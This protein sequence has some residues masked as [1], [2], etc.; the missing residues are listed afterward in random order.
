[1]IAHSQGAVVARRALQRLREAG[2]TA[3]LDRVQNLV[4]LG[5][6][7]YG[8]FSAVFAL[9]GTHSLLPV[10]SRFAVTPAGGFQSTL[11]SMTGL[12]QLLPWDEKRVP[13]LAANRLGEAA[14]WRERVLIDEARLARFFGW[15]KDV[16]TDFFASKTT[17]IVGDNNGLPTAAGAAFQGSELRPSG[18]GLSGDGTVPHSCSVLLGTKTYLAPGTEHSRLPL[19]CSVVAA[20]RDIL[21]GRTPSLQAISSD[22]AAYLTPQQAAPESFALGALAAELPADEVVAP[23]PV[24][25]AIV[26][27][28]RAAATAASASGVRIRIQV[29]IDPR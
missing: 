11:A 14:F 4:L 5:P 9:A 25:D 10:L 27:V 29:D 26:E 12:Y 1:L 15:S 28:L 8:T 16:D 18:D 20:V 23:P 13:W 6:A 2:D 24:A 3:T 19:Y 22:P 17:V 21:A 7:N